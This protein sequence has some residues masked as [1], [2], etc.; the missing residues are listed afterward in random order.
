MLEDILS[1]TFFSQPRVNTDY[2]V[3]RFL[4]L[5]NLTIGS[6]ALLLHGGLLD[7]AT[8]YIELLSGGGDQFQVR[9]SHELLGLADHQHS[10]LV[11]MRAEYSHLGSHPKNLD[12][13][14]QVESGADTSF[15]VSELGLLHRLIGRPTVVGLSG[16]VQV[17]VNTAH[18]PINSPVVGGKPLS[19]NEQADGDLR[20]IEK[21]MGAL[22]QI[23]GSCKLLHLSQS[24]DKLA[25][26]ILSRI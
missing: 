13:K 9:L 26:D 16:G 19:E 4:R 7:N 12:R 14:R 17:P 3:L 5:Q 18:T 11:H 24:L 10:A 2:E 8:N 23:M 15:N 22:E 25:Y 20:N 1:C 6:R 21:K